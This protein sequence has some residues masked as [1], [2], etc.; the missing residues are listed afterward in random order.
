MNITPAQRSDCHMIAELAMMAG[1]GIPGYFWQQ[2]QR[3]G[4]QLYDVGARNAAC[5]DENFSYRNSWLARSEDQIL[6]MLLAYRLPPAQ[7]ADDPRNYPEFLQ[8]LIELE[9]Q[10]PDSFYNNMLATYPQ[11]RWR[12]IGSALMR[13]AEHQAI[14]AGCNEVSLQVFDENEEALRLYQNLGYS[15]VDHRAVI[16]HPCFKYTGQVLLLKKLIHHNKGVHP[17][18][19][20]AMERLQ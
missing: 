10:A 14:L 1:E 9:N 7:Q 19:H 17:N 20:K 6:A 18:E 3:P 8:P 12:G 13:E 11:Y 4:E 15:I 16:A 2:T 5:E